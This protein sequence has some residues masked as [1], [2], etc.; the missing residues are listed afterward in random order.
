MPGLICSGNVQIALLNPDGTNN[1]YMPVKNTVK[2]EIAQGDAN[3]KVR[4]SKMID[5]Y[6]QALDSV[7]TPGSST[8]TIDV[9]EF[10][11]AIAGM[12]FRGDVTK[13][14]AAAQTD[15]KVDVAFPQADVWFPIKKGVYK[16]SEV[17]VAATGQGGQVYVEGTD[18]KVDLAGGM[19]MKIG[20]GAIDDAASVTFSAAARTSSR[21]TAGTKQT[22]LIAVYGRMRNLT[23]GKDVLVDIPQASVYPAQAVDFLADDFAVPS[24]TG[25]IKSVPGNAGPFFVDIEE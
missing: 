4:E 23:T 24:F 16:L 15:V 10:D 25:P 9:D 20:T 7:P 8:L 3:E 14:T 6:G 2:L 17:E 21:I 18:Y 1:G 5:D 12:S 22:L 19:I 13:V 11:S